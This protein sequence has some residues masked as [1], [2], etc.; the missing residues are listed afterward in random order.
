MSS[1]VLGAFL[2]FLKTQ[3]ILLIVLYFLTRALFR[4]YFSSV[5]DV[6]PIS[7]LATISRLGKVREVLSGRTEINQLE[8]HR[9]YGE[10]SLNSIAE[11]EKINS[12]LQF[13]RKNCQNW[14]K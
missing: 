14:T 2:D 3:W 9:K 13:P 5:S 7:F 12:N 6:P 10:A 11:E 1:S 8:A 4:R